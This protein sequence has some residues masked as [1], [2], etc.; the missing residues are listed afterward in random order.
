MRSQRTQAGPVQAKSEGRQEACRRPTL[1]P[2][3]RADIAVQL[4]A[5]ESERGLAA[6]HGV[7][8]SAIMRLRSG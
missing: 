8:R 3:L 5:G 2:L 1:L 4:A 7:P 6:Q